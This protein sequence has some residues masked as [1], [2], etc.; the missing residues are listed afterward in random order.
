MNTMFTTMSSYRLVRCALAL[1]ALLAA[2]GNPMDSKGA[3]GEPVG[4]GGEISFTIDLGGAARA[5]YPP[6]EAMKARMDFTLTMT[7]GGA[8]LTFT[9]TG[10]DTI[11]G[12][13]KPASYQATV[14]AVLDGALYAKGSRTMDIKA[15]AE[16]FFPFTLHDAQPAPPSTPATP[17]TPAVTSVT[18]SAPGNTVIPGGTLQF[19]ASVAAQGGASTLV[20]WSVSGG[21]P[22]LTTA[23]DATGRLTVDASEPLNTVLTVRAA[24]V[25]NST[26]S[27]TATVTVSSF[28]VTLN[29]GST[30]TFPGVPHGYGAQTP[31][32]VT[33]TNSGTQPT[34]TLTVALSGTGA[35]AF[36]LSGTSIPSI[37]S[38]GS[39]TFNITPATGLGTGSYSATVTV[40]GANG[41]SANFG[42]SFDVGYSLSFDSQGGSTVTAQLVSPGAT[43]SV[44]TAPTKS[45]DIFGG[46]Y[47]T[48]NTGWNKYDFSGAV[49]ANI[50]LYA[51]WYTPHADDLAD[52]GSA[53]PV[54]DGIA[55]L[56]HHH[57]WSAG[58]LI[59]GAIA[60]GGN[61][62]TYVINVPVAH[63]VYP[64]SSIF[65]SNTGV[66][67]LLQGGGL[68]HGGN[69]PGTLLDITGQTLILR[70][71]TLTGSTMNLLPLVRVNSGSVIMR[72]TTITGSICGVEIGSGASLTMH[73]GAIS[74]NNA[75][76]GDGGGVRVSSGGTFFM[77]DGTITGNTAS[78][79]GGG[80]WVGGTFTM[81]DG[82]ITGNT[83]SVIGGGVF[84][85]G[86]GVFSLN[87]PAGIGSI[88]GNTG[89]GW[90]NVFVDAGGTFN[91]NG[92]TGSSY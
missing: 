2:C 38:P 70:N 29:T 82:T 52:L 50:T 36:T 37:N 20:S 34:G 91:V 92:S 63:N 5:M 7:G 54:I 46:W 22:G 4:G 53:T 32:T 12:R 9:A 19:S 21:G 18:V 48:A 27:G 24:S 42:L 80:V 30:H 11:T 47:T 25:F 31:L 78:G 60:S 79:N 56:D 17:V 6:D 16:N 72:N 62:K 64:S 84:V 33:V 35:S 65:G 87:L 13:A 26:R 75:A 23:I 59:T 85:S 86:S 8:T 28:G 15:G 77:N 57:L 81:I 88:S 43:A 14:T 3:L 61:N 69:L 76:S 39:D 1:C 67:I 66:K 10:T 90:A 73:S 71:I 44:P 89:G 40:S 58:S 45:G 49:N 74:S 41:I 68:T 55:Y 83:A 51:R